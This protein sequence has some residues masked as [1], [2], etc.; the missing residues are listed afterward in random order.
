MRNTAH[1]K[2]SLEDFAFKGMQLA[3]M[4]GVSVACHAMPDAFLMQHVGV[5]C[6]YKAAAQVSQHDWGSHPNRREGWTQ[7]A[8][9]QLIKGSSERIGP[10]I[11]AWYERRRPN[12][13]TLVSAY[14]IELTGEDFS[15]AVVEAE[16][17]VPCD[18]AMIKTV[19]PN[20]GFFEG[21]AEVMLAVASKGDWKERPTQ[22]KTAAMFGYFFHRHEPDQQADV[23]QLRTLMTAAGF[24]PGPILFSGKPYT[25]MVTASTCDTVLTTA[26]T[27]PMGRKFKRLLKKRLHV[28]VDLPMGLA[29]TSR[30]VRDLAYASGADMDAVEAWITSQEEPAR[31]QLDKFSDHVHALEVAVFAEAPWAAGLVTLLTEMGARVPIVGLRDKQGCLGGKTGFFETLDKN[32]VTGIADMQ[33]MEEPSLRMMKQVCLDRMASG[34]LHAI[35]GSSHELEVFVQVPRTASLDSGLFL[36]ETGFPCD[37]SHATIAKPSLGYGGAVSWAQTLM[38]ELHRPHFG[39]RWAGRG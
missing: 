21:Y 31:D 27:K 33:V 14:F 18:M 15:D 38:S 26:Y 20:K 8:E 1:D 30:F 4:T 37:R 2:Q 11:R 12:F 23:A 34:R 39:T 29:G 5:G 25:E 19:A 24:T 10:F 28:E 32:G 22:E 3:K 36:I 6:K 16:K 9:L 13:M 35:I 17:T 7:V